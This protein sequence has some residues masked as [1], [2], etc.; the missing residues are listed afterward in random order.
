MIYYYVNANIGVDE[1]GAGTIKNPF[2]TIDYCINQLHTRNIRALNLEDEEEVLDLLERYPEEKKN[3]DDIETLNEEP[4][5]EEEIYLYNTLSRAFE[6]DV[7]I[8][9]DK[10]EYH[11]GTLNIYTGAKDKSLT[12]IGQGKD[13]SI[14]YSSGMNNNADRTGT[15]GFNVTFAKLILNFKEINSS[16]WFNGGL[17]NQTYINVFFNAP[18]G[19]DLKFSYGCYYL[20]NKSEFANF[21]FKFINCV[22]NLQTS[23]IDGYANTFTMENCYGLFAFRWRDN[24]F[25]LSDSNKVLQNISELQLD[26]KFNITDN[27]VDNGKIGLYAGEYSWVNN[28]CLLKMN[29]KYYSINEE[30]WDSQTKTF[31]DVG[32]LDFEKGFGIEN[33]TRETTYGN[34][35]FIPLDKFDNFKIVFEDERVKK[36]K[37]NRYKIDEKIVETNPIDLRMVENFNS[38]VIQGKNSKCLIKINGEDNIYKYDFNT[39]EL[40]F[41]SIDNIKTNGIDISDVVNIDFNKIKDEVELKNITFIFYLTQDSIIKNISIDYLEVGEFMQKA[42]N[43]SRL[44]IGYK[45]ITIQPNF[46]ANLVKINVL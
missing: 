7:T 1:I 40:V 41:E 17:C 4:L 43:E 19:D 24:T 38:F 30:F 28:S 29:D 14:I 36:V 11:L 20:Y 23:I 6:D 34:D 46:N 42:P 45:N 16:S 39:N 31:I 37:I 25:N 35:T 13:T 15:L 27:S 9:L 21:N 26:D 32:S 33:L 12:I 10:G 22:S 2:K 44:K 8:F 18:Q 5:N 3:E